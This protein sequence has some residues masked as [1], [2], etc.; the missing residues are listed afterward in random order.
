MGAWEAPGGWFCVP[1]TGGTMW[2]VHPSVGI[3]TNDC[4]GDRDMAWHSATTRTYDSPRSAGEV[5]ALP[6]YRE[7][8]S[9]IGD[10]GSYA[11]L[12]PVSKVACGSGKYGDKHLILPV[13]PARDCAG[14]VWG[15]LRGP[16]GVRRDGPELGSRRG[17]TQPRISILGAGN[18]GSSDVHGCSWAV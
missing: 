16:G 1:L 2:L 17:G 15:P 4:G 13:F 8:P 11:E 7:S 6:V 3:H 10:C 9:P 18:S 12:D 14:L 5:D